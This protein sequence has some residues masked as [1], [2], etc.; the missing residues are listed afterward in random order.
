MTRHGFA[1]ASVGYRLAPE[2]TWPAQ[3]QDCQAAVRFLRAN[4]ERFGLDGN[5]IG[6]WGMSAGGHL[7]A[8]L[9]VLGDDSPIPKTG[10]N[11]TVSSRVQAVCDWF[12]PTQL[13]AMRGETLPDGR[14]NPVG[15]L[16]GGPV[17]RL[18]EKAVQASPLT[19]VSA[20]DPPTF[21]MH[22]DADRLVPLTHSQALYEALRWAG[23]ECQLEVL[24]GAGHGTGG[25]TTLQTMAMVRQFFD[26]H[27]RLAAST[28]P[29]TSQPATD[30]VE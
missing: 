12:G 30:E 21:I 4:A 25:F 2:F 20:D 28:Q 15:R 11:E 19:Y 23:V 13:A 14:P 6:A 8:M 9:G 27:L 10:G 1:V 22:G 17:D 26:A 7:A 16:L 24:P 29:A 5:R 18:R 3:I